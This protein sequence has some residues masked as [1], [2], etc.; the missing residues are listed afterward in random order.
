MGPVPAILLGL[1]KLASALAEWLGSRQLIAAGKAQEAS[2]QAQA[3]LDSLIKARTA[4]N[5]VTH[6]EGAADADYARR[7]RDKYTRAD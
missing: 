7:L 4:T 1:L 2:R 3:I 6:P 5:A